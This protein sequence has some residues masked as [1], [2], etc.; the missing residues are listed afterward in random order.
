MNFAYLEVT[1]QAWVEKMK[2]KSQVAI[3]KPY[4]AWTQ[5]S[6]LQDTFVLVMLLR[7]NSERFTE[8]KRWKNFS[9]R[10]SFPLHSLKISLKWEIILEFYFSLRET[11][12]TSLK[13]IFKKKK[14]IIM[15]LFSYPFCNSAN[16]FLLKYNE[17]L[18]WRDLCCV[19]YS[20]DV[21]KS[22]QRN[23]TSE[24]NPKFH[25]YIILR[26]RWISQERR[27]TWGCWIF[28]KSMHPPDCPWQ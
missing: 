2:K 22:I 1:L 14:K 6:Y 20:L 9:N 5:N 10:N 12:K 7:T 27:K 18:M 28:V 24:V 15:K 23:V 21:G 13:V 26:N 25:I 17:Q 19:W 8:S 16:C 4:T 11:F 3:I